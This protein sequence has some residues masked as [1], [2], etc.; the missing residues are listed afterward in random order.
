MS[1]GTPLFKKGDPKD[2]YMYRIISLNDTLSKVY[3]RMVM[4]RLLPFIEE[5]ISDQQHGFRKGRSTQGAG[6]LLAAATGM[7][8]KPSESR[9]HGRTYVAFIDIRKA[10][11]TVYRPALLYKL[12]KMGVTGH[13]YRAVEAMYHKVQNQI[14]MA[15]ASSDPYTIETGLREGSVLSPVLYTVFINDL[16]NKLQETGEGVSI[17]NDPQCRIAALGYADDLVL[18]SRT[19]QGL[20]RMLDVVADYAEEH[21]FQVSQSKS[22]VVVFDGGEHDAGHR[23]QGAAMWHM[24]GMYNDGDMQTPDHLAEVDEYQYLGI[25][26]HRNRTWESQF[27]KAAAKFWTTVSDKWHNAGAVRMGAGE[28][29]TTKMWESLVAPTMDYNP[30]VTYATL[31]NSNTKKWMKQLV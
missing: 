13:M 17:A 27:N 31:A 6:M 12:H 21:F 18:V 28:Q 14:H 26:F 29:V 1:K 15:G 30:I 20:Q 25:W 23:P 9:N 2:A 11:P 16:L 4:A 10:Y 22:N 3:E 8:K 7:G 5:K 19:P 24:H